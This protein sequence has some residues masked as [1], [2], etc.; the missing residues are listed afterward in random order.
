MKVQ[1]NN[2]T[3]CTMCAYAKGICAIC[4][5]EVMDTSMYK[6]SEG[7]NFSHK[8]SGKEEAA[9]KSPEQ[10]SREKSQNDLFEYLQS[11]GQ[12]G[13]M[14]TKIAL[15]KAGQGALAAALVAA[16]GGL[17]AAADAM[18]LSKRLLNE[19]MEARKVAKREA[20]QQQAAQREEERQAERERQEA[21]A[22]AHEEAAAA[23]A[24]GAD[25]TGGAAEGADDDDLPPGVALPASAAPAQDAP[26]SEAPAPELAP[27]P[28]AVPP[29]PPPPRSTD[30]RWQYDPNA[31]LYYQL[32]TECYFD[33]AK[34]LYHKAG[35][36]S[37][38]KPQ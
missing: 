20:A 13:R 19:E 10:L 8:M 5:K 11:T 18:G 3:Y 12:V 34:S 33:A 37:R 25:A 26:V 32:S 38:E 30:S 15:E 9:F 2:A 35:R 6:M 24:E 31:G 17:H 22:L 4:G 36:W 14:P 7:G 21:L 28:A 29:P 16:F 23:Q 1:Q 27:A